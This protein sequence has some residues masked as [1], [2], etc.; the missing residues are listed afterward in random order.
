MVAR[1]DRRLGGY[2]ALAVAFAW[3]RHIELAH[4]AGVS[5]TTYGLATSR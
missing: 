3:V 2:V 1:E 5:R 4:I